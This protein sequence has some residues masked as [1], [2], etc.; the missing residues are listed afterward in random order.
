MPGVPSDTGVPLSRAARRVVMVIIATSS[1]TCFVFLFVINNLRGQRETDD[2]LANIG[3]WCL[4]MMV[5]VCGFVGALQR[6]KEMSLSFR[7]ASLFLLAYFMERLIW[8][9]A[10]EL[11]GG[12]IISVAAKRFHCAE[13]LSIRS[14]PRIRSC[15]LK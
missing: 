4:D 12:N 11:P 9:Q 5:P 6:R 13:V 2:P 1:M 3:A 15:L 8:V 7:S 10:C 14:G